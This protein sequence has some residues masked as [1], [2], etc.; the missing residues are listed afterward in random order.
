M[1]HIAYKIVPVGILINET[2]SVD[3][4]L[5]DGLKSSINLFKVVRI[6]FNF[7]YFKQF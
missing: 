2:S 6:T 7:D 1:V 5:K 3:I 4:K